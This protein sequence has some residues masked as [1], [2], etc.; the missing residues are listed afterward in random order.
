MKSRF[1]NLQIPAGVCSE[2]F[3]NILIIKKWNWDYS[4]CLDFQKKAQSFIQ[5]NRDLKIYIFCN[6]P[7]CFTL[8]RGNERGQEKLV[9][10]DPSII[11]NLDF[12][13]F[14]IYRGG[15]ITFH[16]PGQWIFYPI[17]AIKESLSLED[18]SCWLLKS[19]KKILTDKFN[20]SD[21]VTATK[22]MG[23]WRNRQ[24]L[25]SIGIGI[26]RFVTEH[27]LA[28]NLVYDEKMFTELKKINPCGI[29]PETYISADS[30]IESTDMNLIESFHDSFIESIIK[31]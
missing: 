12:P 8:G 2:I 4:E 29:N 27:G 11:S 16:Y 23:V 22:L 3:E 21:V 9:A 17:V 25:A 14:N 26:N 6:H 15:G 1:S 13:M 31:I 18:L 24:K 10:F 7:H 30:F 5:E 28:L 19:T 20:I